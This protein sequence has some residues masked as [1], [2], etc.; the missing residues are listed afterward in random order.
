[1]KLKHLSL[2]LFLCT[3]VFCACKQKIDVPTSVSWPDIQALLMEDPVNCTKVAAYAEVWQFNFAAEVSK[4]KN[5]DDEAAKGDLYDLTQKTK[6]VLT[7]LDALAKLSEG[8]TRISLSS[9]VL[10]IKST[11]EDADRFLAEHQAPAASDNS[12]QQQPEME[13]GSYHMSFSD[14]TYFWQSGSYPTLAE[15][16]SHHSMLIMKANIP[17]KGIFYR[18][19]DGPYEHDYDASCDHSGPDI[20]GFAVSWHTL[21]KNYVCF[22]R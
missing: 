13:P 18:T 17:G 16:R 1:M 10:K 19:I 5:K 4:C 14:G 22:I 3:A 9:S 21:K 2:L 11:L 12:A 7:K 20:P 6:E 8:E 15:A